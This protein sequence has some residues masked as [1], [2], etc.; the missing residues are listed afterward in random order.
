MSLRRRCGALGNGAILSRTCR[1]RCRT[2]VTV[3]VLISVWQRSQVE[4]MGPT[5]GLTPADLGPRPPADPLPP[6]APSG[7]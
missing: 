7:R 4:G 3:L 5:L 1:G 6:A 2:P